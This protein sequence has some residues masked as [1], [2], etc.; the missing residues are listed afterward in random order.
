MWV[1]LISE[2]ATDGPAS[3]RLPPSGSGEPL[4]R[5]GWARTSD[6]MAAAHRQGVY[7]NRSG[8]GGGSMR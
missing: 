5:L 7:L 2:E 8:I 1:L 6:G 3:N 4:A